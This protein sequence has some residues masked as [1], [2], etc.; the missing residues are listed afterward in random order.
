[1]SSPTTAF[2]NDIQQAKTHLE[3]YSFFTVTST[4]LDDI[5]TETGVEA[6]R[7]KLD[8]QAIYHALE[9]Q[10]ILERQG[11]NQKQ[12]LT[13]VNFFAKI[14]LEAVQGEQSRAHLKKYKSLCEVKK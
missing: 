3:C 10:D 12:I 11:F 14:Q 13:L 6:A 7:K 8:N 2:A 1:M 9:F 5:K 4:L